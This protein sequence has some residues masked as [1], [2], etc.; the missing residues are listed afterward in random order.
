MDSYNMF[1]APGENQTNSLLNLHAFATFGIEEFR[2]YVRYENIGYFWSD[3]RTNE[4]FGFPISST[5]LRVGL[6]WDFFN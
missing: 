1:F 6:T 4:Q 3:R 2:F 5:R